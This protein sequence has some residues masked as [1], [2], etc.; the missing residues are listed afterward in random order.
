MKTHLLL[1]AIALGSIGMAESA[2]LRK[3]QKAF[4]VFD[5]NNDDHLDRTEWLA[6]QKRKTP[7]TSAMHT[8]NWADA[9][10]DELVDFTEYLA[11]RGGRLAPKLTLAEIFT[12]ADQDEDGFLDP[13]E[14]ADTLNPQASWPKI[15]RAFDRRDTDD[16]SKLSRLEFGGRK[17]LLPG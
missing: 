13:D 14:Y 11:S 16:D 1:A 4:A 12:L 9:D 2:S 3:Y 17:A 10:D 7:W 15:L 5:L 6:T 8:F